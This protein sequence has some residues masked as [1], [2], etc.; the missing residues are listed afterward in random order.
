MQLVHLI[1]KQNFFWHQMVDNP[2]A[3]LFQSSSPYSF[4]SWWILWVVVSLNI[5]FQVRTLLTL[6]E[7]LYCIGLNCFMAETLQIARNVNCEIT[8]M[9]WLNHWCWRAMRKYRA[10]NSFAFPLKFLVFGELAL[11]GYSY[12]IWWKL[13]NKQGAVCTNIS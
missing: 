7:L 10:G 2:E 1:A 4:I 11:F 12:Y 5:Y 13:C 9:N 3:A 6:I 8:L